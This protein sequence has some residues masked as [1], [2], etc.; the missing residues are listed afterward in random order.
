[1]PLKEGDLSL[2]HPFV[3]QGK[4]A[5]QDLLQG[6]VGSQ[7]PLV[8]GEEQQGIPI[9]RFHVYPSRGSITT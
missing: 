1:M 8:A 4:G 5:V 6:P 3:D 7:G 2:L 9:Q